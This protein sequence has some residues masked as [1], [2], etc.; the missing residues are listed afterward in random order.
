MAAFFLCAASGDGVAGGQRA[1]VARVRLACALAVSAFL[2]FWLAAGINVNA[3]DR[4]P[5]PAAQTLTARLQRMAERQSLEAQPDQE[6]GPSS[7]VERRT[8]RPE[9]ESRPR[10]PREAAEYDEYHAPPAAPSPSAPHTTALALPSADPTYYPARELDV[11]P[12]LRT[13]LRFEN[14]ERAVRDRTG[15][16]V[17][18]ALLLD[19]TG[20]VDDVSVVTAEPTGYFEDAARAMLAAARFS[21]AR[22]DG[23]AVKSRVLINVEY[24]PGTTAGTLR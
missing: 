10:Q 22:K 4:S 11:Y 19:E 3:P 18:V 12:V 23:R 9:G 13:P 2:H 5:P 7:R 20:T 16:K 21:P 24:D 17:L 14:P 15:G 1:S 6:P 8:A